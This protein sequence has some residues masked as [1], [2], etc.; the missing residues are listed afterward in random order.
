MEALC[1]EVHYYSPLSARETLLREEGRQQDQA[2]E[3][4]GNAHPG[5]VT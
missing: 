5:S 2:G 1:P 4:L 3:V